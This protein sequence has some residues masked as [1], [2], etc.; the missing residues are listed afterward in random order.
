MK[1][2]KIYLRSVRLEVKG[3]AENHLAMFDSNHMGAIDNLITDV[4]AGGTVIWALDRCS[5]IKSINAVYTKNGKRN[6]FRS[7]PRKRFLCK[8]FKL[9]ISEEAKGEEEYCIKYTICDGREITIDPVI[10]I[11]PPPTGIK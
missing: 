8:G 11:P 3:I 1:C 9:P 10:R 6:V 7:D 4:Q 2:V 5:G